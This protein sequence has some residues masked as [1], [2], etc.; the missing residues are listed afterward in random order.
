MGRTWERRHTAKKNFLHRHQ[1]GIGGV[2][3]EGVGQGGA[4]TVPMDHAAPHGVC[5]ACQ[6]WP[7]ARGLG[8]GHEVIQQGHRAPNHLGP[9]M[10]VGVGRQGD[11]AVPEGR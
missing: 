8:H 2:Q 5:L 3:L 7:S 9:G 10:G 1:G 11:G 4:D 6:S